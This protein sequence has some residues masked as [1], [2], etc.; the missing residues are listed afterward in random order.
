MTERRVCARGKQCFRLLECH[1]PWSAQLGSAAD[2]GA[3]QVVFGESVALSCGEIVTN[4]DQRKTTGLQ[5]ASSQW[6][7][8]M[9]VG[10]GTVPDWQHWKPRAPFL[11]FLQ[12]TG[13]SSCC[14]GLGLPAQPGGRRGLGPHSRRI[15]LCQ[16]LYEGFPG[17]P[18]SHV[19]T[20]PFAHH[21]TYTCGA[22]TSPRT[23][24]RISTHGSVRS[25][26]GTCS[27]PCVRTY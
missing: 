20:L 25:H 8:L 6:S 23:T 19:G 26:L 3:G 13:I 5:S 18:A 15:E 11:W 21:A 2:A 12:K 14:R 7:C 16:G 27:M 4:S 24:Q 1:Q 10:G 9:P 17:I 22:P